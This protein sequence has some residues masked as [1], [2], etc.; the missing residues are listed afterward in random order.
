MTTSRNLSILAEGVNSSGVLQVS[1]GGT[2]LTSITSTQVPYGNGTG[3]LSISSAL[4]FDGTTLSATKFAGA[5]NGTVGATTPSTG[6]FTTLS[7]SGTTTLSG[8]TANGIAYLNGSKVLTTGSALTFDGTLL[9]NLGVSSGATLQLLKLH[10]NG[11]GGNTKAQI[12]FFAAGTQYGLITSGYG[13]IQPEMNFQLPSANAGAFT[14]GV[15]GS[16]EQ[17]RLTSTGLGIGTSSPTSKLDVTAT[18]ADS[19]LSQTVAGVQRWQTIVSYSTGNWSLYNQ[20]YSSTSLTVGASGDLG[21]GVTPNSWGTGTALQG[22]GG[23][24]W[25]RGVADG[26]NLTY[27]YA[28]YAGSNNYLANG[29]A[30][31]YTQVNGQHV[32]YT[33]P[34][35]TAGAT[36]SVTS[37]QIY[38]VTT[39]GSSLL[40]DWQA[41]FS[42]LVAIPTVGQ[43]ITA[44][45]TGTLAG[46]GTVVQNITFNQAMTLNA[47]GNLGILVTPS[48]WQT[49]RRAIEIR[50]TSAGG[51]MVLHSAATTQAVVGANYYNNGTNDIYQASA[52]ASQYLQLNGAHSW[53]TAPSGT[54]GTAISF[55]QS[56]TLDASGNL[57]VPGGGGISTNEAFGTGALKSNTTGANNSAVGYQALYS[58]TTG[59]NNSAVG[60][61]ALRANTTGYS[62]SAMGYQALQNNTTG[63]NNSGLGVNALASNTTGSGNTAINP[64]NSA[65]TYAPV[66][67]PTTENDR[68]CMGSTGV[69]NAYIQVAWTVVSDARDKTDFAPVPHGLDFVTKLKPTAYRYKIDRDATEGHGPVRYGFKA[70]DVLALEGDTPV[71]VDAED[72]D[73]LRFNDQSLI[74]V[75]VNAI[76]ELKSELDE[77]KAKVK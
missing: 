39:L 26:I 27:N 3:S 51:S 22:N 60:V 70:Q 18:G 63:A 4:T 56:M 76:Q 50:G 74:A 77:L 68:F 31:R 58:N 24:V 44:T 33:A 9:T 72:A 43:V 38:T 54:A 67:N 61:N 53:Y 64:L 29:Y 14:W 13:G 65:G 7:A 49:T 75:L 35:G 41:L 37:G 40:T 19:V 5:L 59:N 34:S 15:S 52:S 62:N 32:F 20:T 28:Y 71:V 6:A 23:A 1:N 12:G 57:H 73:K 11:T 21:L 66:F 36:A 46:G 45:A 30:S 48:A 2:G 25:F 47:S 8:G 42:A 17:M 16:A 55:T 10:N 69:T